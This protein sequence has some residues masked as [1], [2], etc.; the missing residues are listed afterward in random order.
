MIRKKKKEGWCEWG[1]EGMRYVYDCRWKELIKLKEYGRG[2]GKGGR[3]NVNDGEE[4]GGYRM[5]EDRRYLSSWNL[6]WRVWERNNSGWNNRWI[7]R[8]IRC[9]DRNGGKKGWKRKF[10]CE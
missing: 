4:R 9:E 3:E 7:K 8:K 10:N 2:G 1:G 5:G 6:G